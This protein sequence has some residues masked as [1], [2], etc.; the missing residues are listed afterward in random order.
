MCADVTSRQ[1]VVSDEYVTQD[2]ATVS[3]K[4]EFEL[5]RYRTK[6]PP[7][8]IGTSAYAVGNVHRLEFALNLDV[9]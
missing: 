4:E 6:P 5:L 7:K 3:M 9:N 8:M 1:I 2:V